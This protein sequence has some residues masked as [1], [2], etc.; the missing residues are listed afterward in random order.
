MATK[1][2]AQAAQNWQQAM[3]S[4]QTSA[5]YTAGI[6]GVTES[7]MAKAAQNEAGYLAGVQQ[8][9]QKWKDRL[10]AVPLQTYKTN[11]VQKGAP[12][13]SS[14]AAAA[15]PK[16]QQ[17]TQKYAPVWA[18]MRA[19]SDAVGGYG[20]AAA[21]QKWMVAMQVLMQAAGKA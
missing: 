17:F 6:N 7:P 9:V 12:R 18:Q 3:A 13:L 14:G 8:N 1:T 16:Y 5:A 10:N 19:A 4:P 11:S 20:M 15:L 21:Q 2:A